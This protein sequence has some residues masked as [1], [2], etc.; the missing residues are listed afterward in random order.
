ML[1][2]REEVKPWFDEKYSDLLGKGIQKD[3]N[4]QNNIVLE[5]IFGIKEGNIWEKNNEIST[6]NNKNRSTAD[7]I[8]L[9]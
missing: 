3:G 4:N 7:H 8:L 2:W 9:H 1:L 6:N 5:T